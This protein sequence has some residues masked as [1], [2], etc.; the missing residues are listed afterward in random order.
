MQLIKMSA[1]FS[2]MVESLCWILKRHLPVSMSHVDE[3]TFVLLLTDLSILY[4]AVVL[5]MYPQ[6]S[7][8]DA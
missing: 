6:I 3:T 8:P 1:S 4:F 5:F 7:G 2:I